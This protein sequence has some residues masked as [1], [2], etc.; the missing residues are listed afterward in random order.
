MEEAREYP[1]VRRSLRIA[2]VRLWVAD[3]T[4]AL[5]FYRDTLRLRPTGGGAADGYA[6]FDAGGT[7]LIVEAAGPDDAD[8][9]GRFAGVSFEVEDC[10]AAH[11]ALTAQ[12]VRFYGAPEPQP[13]GGVL[14]HFFDPAGN[15]LTLVEYPA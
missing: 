5:P 13:W 8:L 6:M 4:A 1:A 2:A 9:I 7:D 3:L 10:A 11:S 15:V 12:G 14:A